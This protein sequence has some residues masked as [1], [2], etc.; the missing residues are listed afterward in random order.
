[1]CVR[2]ITLPR[3]N[4]AFGMFHPPRLFEHLR[5]GTYERMY[6]EDMVAHG[7]TTCTVAPG[8]LA[9]FTENTERREGRI[10]YDS[11]PAGRMLQQMKEVGLVH[12]DIPTLLLD[13]RVN[14][15]P[16]PVA[17]AANLRKQIQDHDWPEL[18]LYMHDE[19][20]WR[21]FEEL[22]PYLTR[23]KKVPKIRNV[24]AM[25]S[26]PSYGL[27]YLHDVWIVRN[28]EITPE[29]LRESQRLGAEVWTY[30]IDLCFSNPLAN[31][32]Y[33]GFYTWAFDLGGNHPWTYHDTPTSFLK[34]DGTPNEFVSLGYVLPSKDG[35]YPV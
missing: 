14:V 5:G 11:W 33:A 25:N 35:R 32:Y 30:A 31:R 29:L 13:G 16:D 12:S 2:P 4:I 15:V 20:G 26:Q 27:G 19:P 23:W 1:M 28:D 9:D 7:M 17:T 8:Q 34:E 22:T 10:R 6:F 18:L 3:P 21:Q 24:T